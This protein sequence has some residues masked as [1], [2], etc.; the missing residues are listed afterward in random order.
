MP[1]FFYFYNIRYFPVPEQWY[2]L[3]RK[4][5]PATSLDL[6]DLELQNFVHFQFSWSFVGGYLGLIID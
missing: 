3:I 1:Y 2:T 6:G 4:N 5:C